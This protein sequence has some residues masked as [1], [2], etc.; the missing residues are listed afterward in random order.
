MDRDAGL[1]ACGFGWDVATEAER[2]RS[3]EDGDEGSSA[4]PEP[5]SQRKRGRLLAFEPR[6]ARV[7]Q[8]ESEGE[9]AQAPRERSVGHGDATVRGFLVR[10]PLERTGTFRHA[11]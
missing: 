9:R 4:A 1:L 10:C 7:Q 8:G 6:R 5:S 2:F 11:R 3:G